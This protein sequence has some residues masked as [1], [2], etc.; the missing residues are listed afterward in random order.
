MSKFEVDLVE[1]FQ[2]RISSFER[3]FCGMHD[4]MR[5]YDKI[6]KGID[7]QFP[8]D[9]DYVQAEDE[10]FYNMRLI[11]SVIGNFIPN[12]VLSDP[13]IVL[14]PQKVSSIEKAKTV[15]KVVN[16]YWRELA[17]KSQL[18][19]CVRDSLKYPFGVIKLGWEFKRKIL[20]KRDK[21]MDIGGQETFQPNE[22]IVKDN[23]FATR[24]SPFLFLWDV[25]AR[26]LQEARWCGEKIIRP[27]E[28]LQRDNRYDKKAL[29]EL[30]HTATGMQ[31]V[32][33]GGEGATIIEDDPDQYGVIYEIHDKERNLLI[34]L[35]KGVPIPLRVIPYPLKNVEGTHYEV[36]VLEEQ[37]D[38]FEGISKIEL[39]KTHQSLINKIRTYQAEHVRNINRIYVHNKN[40]EITSEDLIKIQQA[41]NLSIVSIDG[42]IDD[43]KVLPTPAIP[44]DAY[45]VAEIAKGELLQVAGQPPS[46]FGIPAGGRTTATEIQAM[47]SAEANRLEDSRAIVEDFASAISKKLIQ[48]VGDKLSDEKVLLIAGEENFIPFKFSK[49]DLKGEFDFIILAGSMTKPNREV[50]RQQLMNLLNVVGQFPEVNRMEFIK[51]IFSEFDLSNPESLLAPPPE[52]QPQPAPGGGGVQ[53]ESLLQQEAPPSP[54][55]LQANIATEAGLNR[56][57]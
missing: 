21:D 39:L 20:E 49:E 17:I 35:A 27:I 38:K 51:R 40:S 30:A 11:Y 3:H 57:Q 45:Q 7:P 22:H 24:I 52:P 54:E 12:L 56:T 19:Q 36:L 2:K 44:Q 32:I 23:P 43:L 53:D 10:R 26:N 48:I 5:E 55:G 37:E 15:E 16:Y 1:L 34:T 28:D 47:G 50:K 9:S 8:S 33:F 41:P 46:R 13:D 14:R 4:K 6:Y 31:D 42:D 25:Q 18:K 29:K